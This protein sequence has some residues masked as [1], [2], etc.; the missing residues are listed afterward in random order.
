MAHR[1]SALAEVDQVLFIRDG[2][3]A[4]FGPRDEILKRVVTNPEVAGR[5]GGITAGATP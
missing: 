3:Q 1:P 5:S 4:M 2:M